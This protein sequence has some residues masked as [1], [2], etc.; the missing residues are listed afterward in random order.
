MVE[1]TNL[2]DRIEGIRKVTKL[3]RLSGVVGSVVGCEGEYLVLEA[4]PHK[5]VLKLVCK[6]HASVRLEQQNISSHVQW[7]SMSTHLGYL[8]DVKQETK[9]MA[10]VVKVDGPGNKRAM[11]WGRPGI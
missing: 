5:H 2:I 3:L 7:K 11:V 1:T 10:F 4:M 6:C 9:K 8:N